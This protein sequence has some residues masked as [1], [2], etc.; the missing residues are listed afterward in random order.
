MNNRSV[1][2]PDR[3][4][5]LKM[6]V[7]ILVEYLAETVENYGKAASEEPTPENR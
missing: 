2:Q 7:K 6:F 1:R 4:D 5:L 3:W